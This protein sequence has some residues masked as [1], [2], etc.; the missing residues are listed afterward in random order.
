M[1]EKIYL[2][3]Q[4]LLSYGM[5]I[6][7]VGI[8]IAFGIQVTGDIRDDIGTTDCATRTDG[9]TTYSATTRDCLNSSSAHSDLTSSQAFNGT[10]DTTVSL[11]KFPAKL[12]TIASVIVIAVIISILMTYLYT[13]FR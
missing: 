2:E 9:F 13:R 6:L 12:G 1:K 3:I 4:D 8:A 5:V 10:V 11:A 7:I